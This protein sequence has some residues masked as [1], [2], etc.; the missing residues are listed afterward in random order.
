M[1]NVKLTINGEQVT[2]PSG[3]TILDAATEAGFSIPTFCHD[4]YNPG[5]GA[6]RLCVVEVKGARTLVASCSAMVADGMEVATES[7][8]VVEARKTILEL[9]LANH[10]TDCLTC[11]S[12]GDCRL[13]DYS[14]FYGVRET[15]FAGEKHQYAVEDNNP[16]IVRDMNK[17][18]LCG[19]CV[20]TCA[21]VEDRNVI[22]FVNRGFATKVAPPMD[23]NLAESDCVYCGRCVAVCPV[24]ALAYKHLMGKGRAY[25]IKKEPVVCK[26]CDAGCHF[27]I[28]SIGGQVIGITAKEPA[29]GRPLCLKGRLGLELIYNENPPAP[30]A[31]KDDRYVPA[32]W[33]EALDLE[34][35]LARL[36]EAE[37]PV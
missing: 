34:Q 12:N 24:G 29:Q 26:F 17:C 32:S 9:I 18:I 13:Q 3:T 14:Y 4:P 25:D 8:S 19:K 31:R 11:E 23:T 5:F 15:G 1:A 6:C 36:K 10:P 21:Q 35:V 37:K 30:M 22:D 33:V 16:Y 20:R 7:P 28:N 27:D 2:M